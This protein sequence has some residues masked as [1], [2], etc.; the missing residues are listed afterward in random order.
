MAV[1]IH[2]LHEAKP[3]SQP[4]ETGDVDDRGA[5]QHGAGKLDNI[6]APALFDEV[7][8]KARSEN[9]AN[10]IAA[11]CEISPVGRNRPA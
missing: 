2:A 7:A 4:D 11:R 5:E 1:G 8:Y 6:G 9:E 3:A 10:D